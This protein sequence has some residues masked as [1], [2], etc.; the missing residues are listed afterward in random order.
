MVNHFTN[1][2][3]QDSLG[4]CKISKYEADNKQKQ[5]KN[6]GPDPLQAQKCVRVKTDNQLP[7]LTSKLLR[8]QNNKLLNCI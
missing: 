6:I 8:F 7:I 1:H 5:I 3:K 2:N 4:N